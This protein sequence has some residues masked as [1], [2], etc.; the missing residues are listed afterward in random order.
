MQQTLPETKAIPEKCIEDAA[1]QI[2]C[3]IADGIID[4]VKG[5]RQREE[6]LRGTSST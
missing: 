5:F 4:R 3:S 1:I 2:G 6:L